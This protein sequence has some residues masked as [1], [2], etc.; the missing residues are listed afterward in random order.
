MAIRL[1]F[2][3][4]SRPSPLDHPFARL[5]RQTRL[6]GLL[7]ALPQGWLAGKRVVDLGCGNG[8]IGLALESHGATVVFVEGRR[9]N[10]RH[11]RRKNVIVMDVRSPS[12]ATQVGQT[13]AALAFGILYHLSDPAG[14]LRLCHDIAP[15]LFLETQTIDA[16]AIEIATTSD[17]DS[18]DQALDGA[19]C[20]PS[21]AWIAATLHKAGYRDVRNISSSTANCA[22]GKRRIVYDWQMQN[23]GQA[24]RDGAELRTM[25]IAR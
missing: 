14:F 16:A 13:D 15:T 21:P 23:T 11:L 6:A 10:V 8:E 3:A 2:S 9:E 22:L 1:P 4:K 17:H 24:Q 5:S 18:V 20:R 7:A 19:G 12:L 25:W